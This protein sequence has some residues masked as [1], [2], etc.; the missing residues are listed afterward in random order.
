LSAEYLHVRS[1]APRFRVTPPRNARLSPAKR[2]SPSWK[3]NRSGTTR[4]G[5]CSMTCTRPAF[6]AGLHARARP[7]ARR[8]LAR[9]LDEFPAK[10]ACAIAT[11]SDLACLPTDIWPV[12]CSESGRKKAAITEGH[13]A[14]IGSTRGHCCVRGRG[15]NGL[16]QCGRRPAGAGCLMSM[17]SSRQI[18]ALS[19]TPVW[20]PTSSF[21]LRVWR[22]SAPACIRHCLPSGPAGR[23]RPPTHA[24]SVRREIALLPGIVIKLATPPSAARSRPATGWERPCPGG[25]QAPPGSPRLPPRRWRIGNSASRLCV[26]RAPIS[27]G[28]TR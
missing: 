3:C 22:R 10:G 9:C 23:S 8:L 6:T 18:C 13:H 5:W 28:S 11:R 21:C 14:E 25:Q 2:T 1:R 26:R 27:A 20:K 24:H 19:R 7:A 15:W 12:L 17:S 16:H 4:C